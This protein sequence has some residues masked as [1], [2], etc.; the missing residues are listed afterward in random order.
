MVDFAPPDHIPLPRQFMFGTLPWVHYS[1]RPGV[2]RPD[3][4]KAE[5]DSD[6]IE[7]HTD[8]TRRCFKGRTF[9]G[10][11]DFD[12]PFMTEVTDTLYHGGCVDG[13][14]LPKHIKHVVALYVRERYI[15]EHR[16]DTAL[17]VTMEDSTEQHFDQLDMLAQWVNHCRATGPVLVHCQAGLN[18]SSLVIARALYRSEND[19]SG[20]TRLPGSEIVNL[21]RAKRSPA[22]LCNPSFEKEVMSWK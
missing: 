1:P 19:V 13:L 3:T 16:L 22:V 6:T 15:T 2:D 9:H 12:V 18:R 20:P 17:Y 7:L 11:I 4:R 21:L 8:P 10:E 14:I 5:M